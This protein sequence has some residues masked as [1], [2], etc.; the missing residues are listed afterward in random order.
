MTTLDD[1]FRR[2]GRPYF[3]KIDV[4]G[5]EV[6]VLKGLSSTVPLLSIEYHS[7]EIDR[8]RI[9]LDM[10]KKLAPISV[11]ASNMTCDWLTTKVDDI[12]HCLQTLQSSNAK[13]DL[14][15]WMH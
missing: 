4:E 12:E 9:C 2:F 7:E 10:L 6:D 3:V 8:V 15:V 14:F 13:G 11:R 1:L 5:F